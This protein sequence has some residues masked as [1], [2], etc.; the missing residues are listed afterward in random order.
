MYTYIVFPF[1]QPPLKKWSSDFFYSRELLKI[2]DEQ[3]VHAT[4]SSGKRT[5][6]QSGH[7]A[8]PKTRLV[9]LLISDKLF[10]GG[11]TW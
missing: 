4:Y 9:R 11:A 10:T 2:G 1:F 3:V 7:A 5:G 8:Y 6:W